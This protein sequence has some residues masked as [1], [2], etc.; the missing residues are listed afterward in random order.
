MAM[1]PH[2]IRG[3]LKGHLAFYVYRDKSPK[4]EYRWT[5]VARNEYAIAASGEGY[6]NV[7][8]CVYAINLVTSKTGGIP[9]Q[10]GPGV[11]LP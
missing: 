10:A 11:V 2:R 8:D 6:T 1:A 9:I 5:L 7:A 4:H 3:V